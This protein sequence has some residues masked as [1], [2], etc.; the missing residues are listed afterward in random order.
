[1]EKI[2]SFENINLVF[3]GIDNYLR[4]VGFRCSFRS[5]ID[6]DLDYIMLKEKKKKS[7]FSR[8]GFSGWMEWKKGGFK[9]HSLYVLYLTFVGI[10]TSRA[11]HI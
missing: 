7:V 2:V 9:G 4:G 3:W 11:F 5:D 8:N 1:M 6:F 10:N